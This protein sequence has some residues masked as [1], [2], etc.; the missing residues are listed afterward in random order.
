MS[1]RSLQE[2][3]RISAGVRHKRRIAVQKERIAINKFYLVVMTLLLAACATAT[4]TPTPPSPPTP[5]MGGLSNVTA[6]I[7]CAKYLRE[8]DTYPDGTKVGPGEKFKKVWVLT[9]CGNIDWKGL[10]VVRTKG[11]FGPDSLD[12]P[13]TPPNHDGRVEAEFTAPTT[14]GIYRTEYALR[15][16]S[17]PFRDGFWVEIIVQ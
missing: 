13:T 1:F 12:A 3:R 17:G 16:P 14:P 9:N 4:P 6:P 10:K 5:V 2:R 8:E 7:Y 15:S 11:T